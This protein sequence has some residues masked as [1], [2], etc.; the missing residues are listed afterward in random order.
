MVSGP[1][2]FLVSSCA[3]DDGPCLP[4]CFSFS[5]FFFFPILAGGSNECYEML[6]W[7]TLGNNF[8]I[9]VKIITDPESVQRV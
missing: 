5:G 1:L 7:K 6:T 8:V 9:V 3:I 4:I 2:R